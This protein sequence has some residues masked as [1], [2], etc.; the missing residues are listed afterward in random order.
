ME[1]WSVSW[2][3]PPLI[4]NAYLFTRESD[5]DDVLQI[6]NIFVNVSKGEVAKTN[7]LQKAFNTVEIGQIVREVRLALRVLSYK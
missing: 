5:I 1:K 4:I 3:F 6:S 2:S 7:D